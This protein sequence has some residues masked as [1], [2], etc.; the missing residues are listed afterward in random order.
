LEFLNNDNC[1]FEVKGLSKKIKNKLIFK[2]LNFKIYK[3][4]WLR[5]EGKNGSGKSTL[6]KILAGLDENVEG[7]VFFH[8]KSINEVPEDIWFSNIQLV[9]QYTRKALDPTKTVK[10]NL[11]EPLINFKLI[12]KDER[13]HEVFNIINKCH[14]SENIL[15][16]KANE[17][18]G[19]QYQRI[20]L[21]LSL[22]V[23]PKLLI[24]DEA[25][26]GLD[27][28]NELRMIKILKKQQ[29]MSVI[30]I[31]HNKKLANNICDR[32]INIEDYY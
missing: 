32:S 22:L 12:E 30:F 5:I 26:T 13:L 4:E 1:V 16:K 3:N 8:G 15:E 20:C 24:C 6:A 11:F 27:K 29:D 23:K 14:L 10:Q 19:G 9:T 18:S 31:S 7:E 2:E 28:I 17:L 21:A 25:T